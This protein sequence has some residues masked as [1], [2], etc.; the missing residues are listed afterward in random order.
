M[1]E[2]MT[3]RQFVSFRRMELARYEH[4]LDLA[5]KGKTD[6]L[7]KELERAIADAKLDIEY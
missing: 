6:E 3:D 2:G 5:E 7:V 1:E 4:W